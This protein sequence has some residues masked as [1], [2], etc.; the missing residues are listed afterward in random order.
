MFPDSYTLK[1]CRQC[2]NIPAASKTIQLLILSLSI[3][4]RYF[5]REKTT[6]NTTLNNLQLHSGKAFED[7]T[8]ILGTDTGYADLSEMFIRFASSFNGHY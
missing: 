5:Q 1:N 2:H 3:I 7:S 8:S 6:L 4:K